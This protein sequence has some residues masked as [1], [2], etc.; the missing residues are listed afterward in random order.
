[1]KIKVPY[2]LA[3]KNDHPMV[4]EG[5]MVKETEKAMLLDTSYGQ[6]WYPKSQIEILTGATFKDIETV[7]GLFDDINWDDFGSFKGKKVKVT[8]EEI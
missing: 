8:I 4:I 1:M 3:K 2:W 7:E 6:K 5:T